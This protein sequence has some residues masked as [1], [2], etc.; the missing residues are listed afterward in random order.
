MK[1][2]EKILSGL[3]SDKATEYEQQGLKIRWY[4]LNTVNSISIQNIIDKLK[5]SGFEIKKFPRGQIE[6]YSF[7]LLSCVSICIDNVYIVEFKD[8]AGLEKTKIEAMEF[9]KE[10]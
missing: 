8:I 2:T 1:T 4:K 9:Y 3:I 7:S 5:K 6:A 10:N